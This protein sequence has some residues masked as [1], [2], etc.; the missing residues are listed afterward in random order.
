MNSHLFSATTYSVRR[1]RLCEE[2]KNGLVWILGNE[3]SPKNYEDNTYHF[4]QDS[5]FLYYG[6][7]DL[8][9]LSILIDLDEGKT[10]LCGD[11]R[12]LELVVWMGPLP[13]VLEMAQQVGIEHSLSV[14]QA[15]DHIARAISKNQQIHYLPPY[16]GKSIIKIAEWLA[17]SV[18]EVEA[19]ASL[20]LTK[21]VI[22]QRSIK[23]P[24]ELLQMHEALNITRDMHLE[25]MYETR[26]HLRESDL[27]AHLMNVVHRRNV[28]T[29]YPVILTVNGQTLHN[30]DHSNVLKD[31]QLLLGDFGAE[32]SMHYAGDITRTIPVSGKFSSMQKDIYNIV[33]EGQNTA[34]NL[35]K[36]GI[37]YQ[38]VHLA[39][40]H[41]LASGLKD[42][43]IMKGDISEAVQLGAHALFFPHGLGHMIGLDVHDMEDLG[44]DLLG[45][46]GQIKRSEQFG[47]RSLRFGKKLHPGLV[48]TVE[49][50]L[51][52]IPELI[53]MWS[54]EK[55]FTDF[56]NYDILSQLADFGGV[57]IED[58]YAITEEG[59]KLLGPAIPKK[60]EDI[61]FLM[62]A[63]KPL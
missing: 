39:C 57:R 35:L 56:I 32:S 5:N 23:E 26:A 55:K 58:N 16:R 49:P 22:N 53:N 14:K 52:F 3:E 63:N 46:D 50:G 37:S 18:H 1:D 61:E 25:V 59:S 9:G 15:R 27:V 36:P 11:D 43:S 34:I 19:N 7:L 30:H 51:Y 29:A 8:P 60:I 38:E 31:G 40:A 28:D 24:Q 6:G 41:K 2:I 10:Y 20:S 54:G 45:Y 44:E 42:L 13:T 12:P 17:K 62:S 21:A 48:L 47:L 33:L 4:R